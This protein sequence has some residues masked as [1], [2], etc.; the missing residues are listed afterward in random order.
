LCPFEELPDLNKH[1]S[2][3]VALWYKEQTLRQ[4]NERLLAQVQELRQELAAAKTKGKRTKNTSERRGRN[5]AKTSKKEASKEPQ[6]GHGPTEQPHLE[7]QTKDFE[8]D[9]ADRVCPQCGGTLDEWEGQAE[10]SE[11]IEVVERRFI[12]QT[13]RQKKYR[14]R[15]A[16]CIET[17]PGPE[18][19]IAGGRYSLSFAIEVGHDKYMLHIPL[20]RQAREMN[21]QGL[22]IDSQTLWD[23]CYALGRLLVPVYEAIHRYVL[24]FGW[25]A[26][27]E[28]TWWMMRHRHSPP[29]QKVGEWYVWIAHRPDAAYYLLKPTRDDTSASELLSLPALGPQGEVVLD[30]KGAPK[31]TAYEGKVLCDGWWAYKY[32]ARRTPNVVLVHCWSH[33]R[34]EI[35]AC[36]RAF[37][38]QTEELIGLIAELYAIEEDAA[39]GPEGDKQRA[40]LRTKYS[41]EVLERMVGW[42]FQNGLGVPAESNL[43]KAVGYMIHHWQGLTR[44]LQDPTLPL[45]NNGV[46]KDC[47]QAVQGKKNHYGSR[48][49]RGAETASILYTIVQTAKLSAIEPKTYMRLAALRA[50]RGQSVLIPSEVTALNLREDLGLSET[51][52]ERALARRHRPPNKPP[53]EE[54]SSPSGNDEPHAR[55]P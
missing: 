28:T 52:A 7:E 31:R 38:K 8:L 15:C 19:L 9:D 2:Q 40:E 16:A 41:T 39:P 30:D 27:D 5:G 17:A 10:E 51:E 13:I 37:P 42:V 23:Q 29:E 21:R 44:F 50:L 43:R 45:D 46:E 26:A 53:P 36:E 20:E 48:S 34:R 12:R 32:V 54:C 1:R 35:L 6:P 25:V 49:V 33:V 24:S 18:K 3:I 4:D 55:S 47:R 14:C 22:L 11:L